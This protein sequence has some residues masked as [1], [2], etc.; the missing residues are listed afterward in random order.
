[1]EFFVA[2]PGV[3][4]G[5][6]IDYVLDRVCRYRGGVVGMGIGAREIAFDHRLD[7]ELANLMPIAVAVDTH[8]AD[9][10]LAVSVLDQRHGRASSSAGKS[11]RVVRPVRSDNEQRSCH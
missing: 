1:A 5:D 10:A 2:E 3:L 8:D 11:A 7:I 4:A 9:A 6:D